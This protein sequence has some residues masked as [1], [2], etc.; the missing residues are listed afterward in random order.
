MGHLCRKYRGGLSS[1]PRIETQGTLASRQE[2]VQKRDG[3]AQAG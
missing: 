2:I 3:E 1:V